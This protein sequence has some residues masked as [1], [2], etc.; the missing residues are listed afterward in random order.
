MKQQSTQQ[1]PPAFPRAGS[2]QLFDNDRVTAWDVVYPTHVRIAMHSHPYDYVGVEVGDSTRLAIDLEGQSRTI[3]MRKG[4]AWFLTKGT[5]HAEEG[6]SDPPPHA[7]IIDLKETRSAPAVNSSGAPAAFPRTGAKK[8]VDNARV[9]M[10]DYSWQPGEPAA[11]RFYENDTI[12]VVVDGD[13]PGQAIFQR[14]NQ[15]HTEPA[16]AAAVHAVFI[17]LK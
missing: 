4:T 8:L 1:Y 17:E 16:T 15:L 13:H 14:G 9:T 10:W 2:T 5:T 3:T 11:T 12:E 7:I 6:T